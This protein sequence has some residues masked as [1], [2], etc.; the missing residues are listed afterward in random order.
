MENPE[1]QTSFIFLNESLYFGLRHDKEVTRE[2]I[3][4]LGS[5]ICYKC[6]AVF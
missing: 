5:N 6:H 2:Q 3:W 1:K 4:L